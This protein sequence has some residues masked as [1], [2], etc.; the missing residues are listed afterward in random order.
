MKERMCPSLLNKQRYRSEQLSAKE[1]DLY[2][3]FIRPQLSS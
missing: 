1:N 2:V 3:P